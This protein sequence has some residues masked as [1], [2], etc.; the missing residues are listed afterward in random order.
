[1]TPAKPKLLDLMRN[2]MRTAHYSRRTEEAYLLWA[3]QFILFHGKRHPREMAEDEVGA[4]LIHEP[5]P[6]E[7]AEASG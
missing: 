6:A 4:F 5:L 7:G 1:M 2:I 3:R